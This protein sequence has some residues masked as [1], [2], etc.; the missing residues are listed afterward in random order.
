MVLLWSQEKQ[1][2]TFFVKA[3]TL[4]SVSLDFRQTEKTSLKIVMTRKTSAALHIAK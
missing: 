1:A 4:N 2:Y 3:Q